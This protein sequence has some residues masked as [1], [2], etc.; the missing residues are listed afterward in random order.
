VKSYGD[1]YFDQTIARMLY[2]AIMTD[3]G[4]FRFP[5]TDPDI[6]RIAAS[7]IEQGADPTE[8]YSNIYETW[9]P[10]RM[11]LLGEVLDTMKTRYNGKLA[12]LVCTQEMFQRTETTEVE[13]DNFSTYPMNVKGVQVGIL[14]NELPDGVKISFRSKGTIPANEMAKE[15]GG[16][17]HLNAAGVRLYNVNLEDVIEKAVHIAGKYLS[18]F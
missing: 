10:N 6:H 9:S 12:Y 17:G 4:S 18:N 14:F 8:I 1:E 2:A 7:L 13:T 11:R 3:T 16:N 5:R 15:L